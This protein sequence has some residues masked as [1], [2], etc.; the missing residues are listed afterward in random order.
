MTRR[1]A[2]AQEEIDGEDKR[3]AQWRHENVRR[4][5][6]YAPFIVQYLRKLAERGELHG[7]VENAKKK[8]RAR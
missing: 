2:R 6:D 4:R 5:H 1:A 7:L 8:A 3:M